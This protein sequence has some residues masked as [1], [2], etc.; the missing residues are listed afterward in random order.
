M[1]KLLTQNAKMKKTSQTNGIHIFNFGIP[2]FRSSTGFATCPNA[3]QCVVG[4]YA[5]SGAYLWSTVAKAYEYRLAVT[6]SNDFVAQVCAEIDKVVKNK[7]SGDILIRVHDS[8]DFYSAEYLSKW[9]SVADHYAS[10]KRVSFYAYTKM[11]TLVKSTK[12]P[13]N[14]AFI[15]SYGGREDSSIDPKV[16]RHSYVFD[17]EEKLAQNGYIDASHDDSL[18]L[19]PINHRI[20]LVYHGAKNFTN[21]NW[22]KVSQVSQK[23]A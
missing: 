22:D 3:T 5:K 2:A 6:Q 11:V 9:L 17:S 15:F 21:T 20:G 19:S 16:D 1:T 13:D 23:V 18:A 10:N 4:C 14:F 12:V 7:K 8:G